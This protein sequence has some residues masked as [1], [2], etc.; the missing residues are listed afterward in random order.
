M[1]V[2]RRSLNMKKTHFFRICKKNRSLY[3]IKVHVIFVNSEVLDSI[4]SITDRSTL[5]FFLSEAYGHQSAPRVFE[6]NFGKKLPNYVF[7][8][9]EK[10]TKDFVL[11]N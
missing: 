6:R 7:C 10:H 8:L 11:K 3:A 2:I 4:L 5:L 1:G 9:C